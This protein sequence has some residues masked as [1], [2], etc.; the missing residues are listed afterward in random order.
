MTLIAL[1][2]SLIL[3]TGGACKS[4]DGGGEKTKTPSTKENATPAK[5]ATAVTAPVR[6]GDCAPGTTAFVSG[7]QPRPLPTKLTR[8]VALSAKHIQ[9]VAQKRGPLVRGKLN[10]GK[11][12]PRS[13]ER[14]G[15]G[16][17]MMGEGKMGKKE[18]S[19]KRGQYSMQKTSGKKPGATGVLKAPKGGAFTSLKGSGDFRSG[20]EDKSVYDARPG[21]GT[22]GRTYSFGSA[23]GSPGGSGYGSISARPGPTAQMTSGKLT[24]TGDLDR[25]I[26]RRY[27]RRNRR[28]LRHCYARRLALIPKLQGTV[29]FTMMISPVGTVLVAKAKGLGDEGTTRCMQSVLKGIKFPKPRGSSVN[30]AG[31]MELSIAPAPKPRPPIVPTPAK[32]YT[33][34]ADNPIGPHKAAVAACL[35]KL[36]KAHG[37]FVVDL[38]ADAKGAI[39]DAKTLGIGDAATEKCIADAARKA[40]VKASKLPVRHLRCSGSFGTRPL[41][42]PGRIDIGASAITVDGKNVAD[43]RTLQAA[44]GGGRINE[45]FQRLRHEWKLRSHET[46]TY[47]SVRLQAPWVVRP[48]PETTA[49]VFNRV[50]T[51][52]RIVGGTNVVLA[53]QSASGWTLLRR[54]VEL[55]AVPIPAGTGALWSQSQPAS[56]KFVSLKQLRAILSMSIL[57]Q[58]SGAVAILGTRER[59]IE[60]LAVSTRDDA[61][62]RKLAAKVASWRKDKLAMTTKIQIAAKDKVPYRDLVQVIGAVSKAGLVHWSVTPPSE[63]T[64]QP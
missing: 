25:A 4:K 8:Q 60:K 41:D 13:E 11:T 20:L 44:A 61:A 16:T 30:V 31:S 32:P 48:A 2:V 34:G 15:T 3:V 23:K 52:I 50:L 14:G 54:A 55:P 36:K 7:M 22:V 21:T 9:V 42:G 19:R 59:V 18:S 58:D 33:A 62:L 64:A 63:L 40:T 12:D 51:T 47:A 37:V 17:L 24:V 53:R 56:S 35:T 43:V 38:T 45:L 26:I 39:T 46:E 5:T 29:N 27:L 49:K 28:K 57:L 1:P 10:L 6:F